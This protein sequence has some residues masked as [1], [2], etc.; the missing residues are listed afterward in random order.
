MSIEFRRVVARVDESGKSVIA[1]NAPLEA[2]TSAA[3]PGT[4]FYKVWG[5]DAEPH[6]PRH[7]PPAGPRPLLPTALREPPDLR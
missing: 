7:G 5:T 2:A 3:M 6:A 1:E 4:K